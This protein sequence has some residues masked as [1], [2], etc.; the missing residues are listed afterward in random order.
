MLEL[1]K[2]IICRCEEELLPRTVASSSTSGSRGFAMATGGYMHQSLAVLARSRIGTAVLF[3][4]AYFLLGYLSQQLNI[5]R[6][7][8][9][10]LWLPGGL[11][12][13]ALLQAQRRSWLWLIGA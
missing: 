12:F 9:Y 8:L 4:M 5:P 10:T 1:Y 3:G 11:L 7:G 2:I 6:Y 13:G